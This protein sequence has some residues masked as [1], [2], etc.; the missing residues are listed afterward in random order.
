MWRGELWWV[1][2]G[3]PRG[4]EPGYYRPGVIVSADRFNSSNLQTV[5][6]VSCY[7]NLKLASRP[8][9]VLLPARITGLAQDTV[10]NVTQLFV[11][12][13]D[14]LDRLVGRVPPSLMAKLDAGLRLALHL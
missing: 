11:T 6:L 10:A 9:N 2:A 1:D 3:E 5:T 13:R 7:S 12:D 8:G 4:S 14:F